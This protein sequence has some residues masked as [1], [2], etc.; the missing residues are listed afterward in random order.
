MLKIDRIYVI[1]STSTTAYVLNMQYTEVDF[2]THN[3]EIDK[4]IKI[5]NRTRNI[6]VFTYLERLKRYSIRCAL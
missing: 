1:G 6:L 5:H 3:T 4:G 2:L